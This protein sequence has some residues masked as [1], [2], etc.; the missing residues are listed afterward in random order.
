M[1]ASDWL[2]LASA[3]VTHE[4][5]S[6][7]DA[8]GVPSYAVGVEYSAREVYKN[9]KV[10]SFDGHEVVARGVVWVLGTPTVGPNDR[11]TLSDSTQPPILS[12]E[13]YSDEGGSHH[14]KVYFG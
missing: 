8:Y 2:D 10:R 5:F 6:S 1:S 11:I 14:V 7:R 13:R 9:V 12:V 3:T 4:P